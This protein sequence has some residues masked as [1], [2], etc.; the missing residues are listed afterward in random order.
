MKATCLMHVLEPWDRSTSGTEGR[1]AAG[2]LGVGRV[3]SWSWQRT[4]YFLYNVQKES[5]E[6]GSR[7][8]E[9]QIVWS[10]ALRGLE[11]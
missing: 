9:D 6:V 10:L 3:R 11:G 1:L 5:P 7:D 4:A 8:D 2:E